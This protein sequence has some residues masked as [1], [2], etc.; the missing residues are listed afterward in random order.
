[1]S[2]ADRR[3]DFE[4]D[5]RT[6]LFRPSGELRRLQFRLM[7]FA[8]GLALLVTLA[9]TWLTTRSEYARA[10]TRIYSGISLFGLTPGSDSPMGALGTVLFLLYL[11]LALGLLVTAPETVF[12]LV[13]GIAGLVVTFMVVVNQ[14][15]KDESVHVDWTGAPTVALGLWLLAVVVAGVA[16][17]TT[18]A[19]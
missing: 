5:V 1:M 13:A 14:P 10:G 4:D 16:R 9:P 12:A 8:I 19:G 6:A 2:E 15:E 11:L 3:D 7:G 17:T 18:R